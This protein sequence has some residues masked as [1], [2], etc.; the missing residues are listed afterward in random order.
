MNALRALALGTVTFALGTVTFSSG[1]GTLA[2]AA[3]GGPASATDAAAQCEALRYADFSGIAD[4]PTQVTDTRVVT[5]SAGFPAHCRAQGYIAPNIGYELRL[6]L[7]G[8]NGKF[9]YAGC[10]GHCGIAAGS[11]W[12]EECN[13]PL[14]KGY[15]CIVSDL[16]HRGTPGD[17]LWAYRRL[18]AKVDF[19]FR[20]THR[21]AVSGKAITQ[22]F[23]AA[24]PEKSYYMGCST[25][26]RQGLIEAQRFPWDVDGIIVGAPVVSQAGTSLDFIW[27]LQ[28]LADPNGAP[29]LT[30][31]DLDLLHR[32]AV[33]ASDADDGLEDGVIGDPL[34][35]AFDPQ[36]LACREGQSSE[37]LS[38][39]KM[40]AALRIYAG[41]TNLAGAKLYPG[42]GLP[43]G[44]ERGWSIFLPRSGDG[45]P[46]GGS[47]IDSM[48][49]M[50]TDWG[51]EWQAGD[52]DF[53]LDY[54]RLGEGEALYAAS[55]P[56]LRA[57][58]AAGGKLLLYQGWAD[59][60]IAPMNSLDYYQ[61][62]ERTMGGRETTEDF[63][64]LF[65]VPG[66]H[67]CFGGDGAFAIDYISAMEAWVERGEA[68]EVLQAAHL[69]GQH[70]ASSMIRRFPVDT[71]LVQFT[72]PVFPYPGKARYRGR[73]DPD[74][75]ASF[76]NADARR[77][78]N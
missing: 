46:A 28:T 39:S 6:P 52:F 44:S 12:A 33:A 71:E 15:A 62:V 55:D 37:C 41:P 35:A 10:T 40:E 36:T 48:R 14:S 78:R 17:G 25:G 65:M 74:D 7:D 43:P 18:E 24:A 77:T 23:Y 30:A 53:D 26:G 20:A 5:A 72:R 38:A 70:D 27:N 2:R 47:G 63:F 66:M 1:T 16:G 31:A 42:A 21:T 4:A 67:H 57:F 59:P 45:P 34:A 32:A 3:D 64:R 49:Y 60:I 73:G 54:K 22:R 19:A 68:P 69:E 76:E 11:R 8:W 75:A 58:K 50:V 9:F 13:Y 51:P 56:D 61:A 29:V